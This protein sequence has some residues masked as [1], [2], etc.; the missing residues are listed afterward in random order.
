M[1]DNPFVGSWSYRSFNNDPDFHLLPDGSADFNAVEFGFGTLVIQD[2]GP[3]LLGGSIGGDGWSLGLQGS[4]ATGNPGQVRF[5]GKG[6]VGSAEWIYDYLGWLV[7]AW[8]NGVQQH[9]ALVV[10]IVRTIPH[11]GGGKGVVNPAGVVD[12]WYAVLQD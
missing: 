10:Y 5:Q 12:S 3:G 1:S 4:M 2:K 11:P 7:P 8:P 6:V 9:R